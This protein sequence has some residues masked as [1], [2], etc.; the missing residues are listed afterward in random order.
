MTSSSILEMH[1][2]FSGASQTSRITSFHSPK[3]TTHTTVGGALSWTAVLS[4]CDNFVKC[5]SDPRDGALLGNNLEALGNV[6]RVICLRDHSVQHLSQQF[7]DIIFI[8]TP[9]KTLQ[10][11][12]SGSWV[13]QG[14]KENSR[15]PWFIIL[16]FSLTTIAENY[17]VSHF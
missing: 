11:L 2:V 13:T 3:A 7:G 14:K 17:R 1:C 10:L 4:G 12:S 15:K 16:F 8:S 5:P 9:L 6:G